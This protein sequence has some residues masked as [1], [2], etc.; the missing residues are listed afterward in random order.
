MP[1][2]KHKGEQLASIP[3]DYLRWLID[4]DWVKQDLKDHAAELLDTWE[5]AGV[6]EDAYYEI[7]F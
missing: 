2:G 5:D 3:E 1:F 4:Q 7:P 6:L